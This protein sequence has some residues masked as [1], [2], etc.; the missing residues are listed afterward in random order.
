VLTQDNNNEFV[1]QIF[2]LL[3]LKNLSPLNSGLIWIWKCLGNLQN[4]LN[5]WLEYYYTDISPVN[6]LKS[7]NF[8]LERSL[9]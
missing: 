1:K 7:S 6:I 9:H 8:P 2:T 3:N 5:S 4:A